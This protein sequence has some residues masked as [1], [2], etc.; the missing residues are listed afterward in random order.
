[1]YRTVMPQGAARPSIQGGKLE[2]VKDE[3]LR[4]ELV[5]FVDA[6]RRRRAPGVT[7]RAG[8]NALALAT[9]IA[10]EMEAAL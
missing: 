3:P 4:L 6:A 9:K 2:V 7:A 5:D 1:M 10:E 8:R